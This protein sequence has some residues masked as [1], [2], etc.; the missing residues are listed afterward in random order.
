VAAAALRAAGAS[1]VVMVGGDLAGLASHGLPGIA[2]LHPGEGPLGGLLTALTWAPVDV[3]VV[4]TCD[5]AA[6]GPDE[7]SAL[8]LGLRTEGSAAAAAPLVDGRPQYLTAAYRRSALGPLKVRFD[9]GERAVRRAMEVSAMK[10]K[11]ID[12]LEASHLTDVDTPEALG[13]ASG[14]ACHPPGE[15]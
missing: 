3:V 13:L 1:E 2:D 5:L 12:G 11:L 9:A 15:R 8:V 4:L 6:I 14:S 10:V 7:V